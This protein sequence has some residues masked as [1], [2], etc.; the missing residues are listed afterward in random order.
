LNNDD[1]Q[2]IGINYRD[3]EGTPNKTNA[4]R[5]LLRLTT[6]LYEKYQK[7]VIVLIDEYDTPLNH[8]FRE[9]FYKEAS[10]FFGTFYS[11]GLKGNSAL[12]KACLMGI[13]EVRG[14]GILS[15]LNNLVTCACDKQRFSQYFG[16]TLD[17]VTAFL[18]N[19]EKQVQEV[20]EWYN[21]YYIGSFQ[22]IN[23]WSFMNYVDSNELTSYWVQTASIDSIRTILTPVLS[24]EL[25][26]ILTQVYEGEGYEIG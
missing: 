24:V 8:A 1:I 17:E 3:A 15:G 26:Q 20:K 4:L 18:D 6:S 11:N 10:E 16:F 25:I 5:F 19:N 23:P 14:S 7:E 13:V 9:G 22:V 21:G 12:Y 2:Q